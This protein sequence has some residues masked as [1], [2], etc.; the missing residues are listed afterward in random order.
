MLNNV[1]FIFFFYG[2]INL[3]ALRFLAGPTAYKQIEENGLKP[4]LFTQLLAASGGPKWI[5]IAGLD[6]Y[7]FGEFFKERKTPLHTL[8]A[9]SGAWRLACLGQDEPLAA[10]DRLEQLYI[11]QRYDVKPTPAEVSEQVTGIITGLLGQAAGSTLIRDWV[12]D[13]CGN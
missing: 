11:G 6:K 13:D 2:V 7:L 4:E 12:G 8:G 1:L 10:Y 3:P 9:S 5:G